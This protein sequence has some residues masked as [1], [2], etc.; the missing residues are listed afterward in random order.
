MHRRSVRLAPDAETRPD[1]APRE[2]GTNWR[3]MKGAQ[4]VVSGPKSVAAR[5]RERPEEE[6]NCRTRV[7]IS[8][9]GRAGRPG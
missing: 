3:Q 5:V 1:P 4:K 6:G 7:S 8:S 9:V 2:P